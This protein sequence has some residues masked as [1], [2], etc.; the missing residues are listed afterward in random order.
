[1]PDPY[2]APPPKPTPG[3][4]PDGEALWRP[5]PRVPRGDDGEEVFFDPLSYTD[6]GMCDRFA[7]VEAVR[8]LRGEC[9]DRQVAGATSAIGHGTGGRLSASATAILSTER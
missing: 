9:G 8:Q 2:R 6:A 1:M 5:E 7:L 3:T 4:R